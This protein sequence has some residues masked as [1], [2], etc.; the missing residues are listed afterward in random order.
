MLFNFKRRLVQLYRG[1]TIFILLMRWCYP[2][3]TRPTEL[4][5]NSVNSLEQQC[6]QNISLH[7]AQY[8]DSAPTNRCLHS[9]TLCVYITFI[10]FRLT[11]CLEHMIYRTLTI[12]PPRCVFLNIIDVTWVNVNSSNFMKQ[13]VFLKKDYCTNF[14][15]LFAVTLNYVNVE[16]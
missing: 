7:W 13:V 14:K 10:V 2:L 6:T 8:T 16:E 4:N 1:I 15:C 12:T 9:F 11:R 5:F 3:C